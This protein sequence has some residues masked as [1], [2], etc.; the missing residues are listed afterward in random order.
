ML[1]HVARSQIRRTGEA[2]SGLAMTGLILGWLAITMWVLFIAVGAFAA[3]S[4]TRTGW[5][6]RP[7]STS[8]SAA[9]AEGSRPASRPGLRARRRRPGA[10]A[11]M[12][13]RA[14]SGVVDS[15]ATKAS[16]GTSTLPMVF[17]RF[18]PSFC[19]SSSLR[20]RVMSPP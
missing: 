5:P 13:Q 15:A 4:L 12:D 16:W 1:G 3:M 18:L 9:T 19:R 10:P 6:T 11:T 2:G 17:I 20:L 7:P 14:R 8:T